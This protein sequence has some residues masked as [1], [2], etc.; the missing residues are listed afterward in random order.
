MRLARTVC[1]RLA[2]LLL[3]ASIATA[4]SGKL[5]RQ[6]DVSYVA[7]TKEAVQMMLKLAD[8]KKIR[9]GL[10]PR[11]RRRAHRHRR[12]E[13]VRCAWRRHRH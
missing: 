12:R 11:V 1:A 9:R 2:V 8:V 5:P 10:R 4:Q 13:D 3:S 7:T 6:P